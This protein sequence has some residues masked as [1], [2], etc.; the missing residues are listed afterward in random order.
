M[1]IK[2]IDLSKCCPRKLSMLFIAH[3]RVT[4]EDHVKGSIFLLAIRSFSN[5]QRKKIRIITLGSA[6]LL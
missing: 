4:M 2:V 1:G 6:I 3:F 5:M